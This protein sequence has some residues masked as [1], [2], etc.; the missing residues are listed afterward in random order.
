MLEMFNYAIEQFEKGKM[1]D[2]EYLINFPEVSEIGLGYS[3]GTTKG[4]GLGS[5][6]NKLVFNTLT[7][8]PDL[9]KR[10]LRHI[11]EL[12]LV[13]LGI[14]ADRVSDITANILKFFLIEYT[15]KQ[16][17]IWNIPICNAVPISHI[18]NFETGNWEDRYEDLPINPITGT[19]L[20][21]VPRRI[22]RILPWINFDDYLR[23]EFLLFLPSKKKIFQKRKQLEST[24][25]KVKKPEIVELTRKEIHR[26]DR[27][28]IKKERTAY[29]AQPIT[30][31][32]DSSINTNN[33]I[34]ELILL[35]SGR[36][37]A[38]NYQYLI[39]KFLNYL[40]EPELVD[41]KPQV[42]T[43]Y[44]TEIRDIVFTNESDISFWRFIRENHQNFLVV[45]ELKN[46]E[47]IN[48]SDIDQLANYLGDP[49][50]YLGI[51]VSRKQPKVGQ[52]RKAFSIYNKIVPRKV[53]LF[54]SDEDI[55]NMLKMKNSGQEP[56]KFIQQ[57][58]RDFM[59]S[60][61]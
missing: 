2:S 54:I 28:I 61:E 50:G 25:E 24:K 35:K 32:S 59:T 11:E 22:V 42:R 12:Q 31:T 47:E 23:S 20:L 55:E 36:D 27:Y 44:G 34:N 18:F 21:F 4:S 8:S 19:P 56:T 30:V 57:K 7:S 33:F 49:T 37:N 38:Y 51:L 52:R 41:G 1:I 39:L 5:Y 10:K 14:N 3:V 40:F 45:F 53:I 48:N 6:L 43:E 26:I 9:V 15:K 16:C 60:I 46:K 13:S 58:Y 29:E 17:Q